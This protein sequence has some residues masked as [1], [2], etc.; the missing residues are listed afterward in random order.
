MRR[1]SEVL[2]LETLNIQHAGSNLRLRAKQLSNLGELCKGFGN[3]VRWRWLSDQVRTNFRNCGGVFW[4]SKRK[5]V[6]MA[7]YIIGLLRHH[8]QDKALQRHWCDPQREKLT[9]LAIEMYN[10][11]S[12]LPGIVLS[13]IGLVNTIHQRFERRFFILHFTSVVVGIG[14]MIMHCTLVY[15]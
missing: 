1:K 13:L 15:K 14:S 7:V 10:S 9:P 8:L 3:D 5:R 4:N 6:A 2:N 11:V 12:N